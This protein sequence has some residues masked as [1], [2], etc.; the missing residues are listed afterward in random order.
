MHVLCACHARIGSDEPIMFHC[1]TAPCLAKADLRISMDRIKG[2]DEDRVRIMQACAAGGL[3]RMQARPDVASP[4]PQLPQLC[5]L[6][7]HIGGCMHACRDSARATREGRAI[8]NPY[9]NIYIYIYTY[10]LF[11][12]SNYG[13]CMR[14]HACIERLVSGDTGPRTNPSSRESRACKHV[15]LVHPLF[16]NNRQLVCILRTEHT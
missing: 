15:D 4:R 10:F 13:P 2:S 8:W 16:S 12:S 11:Q 1:R 7:N 3:Q 9:I 14:P 6:A 5:T